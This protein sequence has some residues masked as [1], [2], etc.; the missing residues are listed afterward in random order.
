MAVVAKVAEL[1]QGEFDWS[2]AWRS[3]RLDVT[4]LSHSRKGA[5]DGSKTQQLSHPSSEIVTIDALSLTLATIQ[6]LVYGETP[7]YL[8]NR[9]SPA[10]P[11][12]A[13]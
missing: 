13:V 3:A 7:T 12:A 11:V 8:S 1:D 10:N 5:A 9:C 4:V 6:R 2:L